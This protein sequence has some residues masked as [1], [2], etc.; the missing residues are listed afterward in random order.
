MCDECSWIWPCELAKGKEMNIDTRDIF[1][2]T[3]LL[4]EIDRLRTELAYVRNQRNMAN[5]EIDRMEAA[6]E[7]EIEE[8]V[9][10]VMEQ[11]RLVEQKRLD[12]VI[13]LANKFTQNNILRETI[14]AILVTHE[15]W[16]RAMQNEVALAAARA[17]LE[18]LERVAHINWHPLYVEAQAERDEARAELA[19]ANRGIKDLWRHSSD[20]QARLDAVIEIV[21]N[22]TGNSVLYRQV[23]SA[24]R[25]ETK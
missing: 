2:K 21:H 11:V 19:E 9:G 22:W 1:T 15:Q 10:R 6:M 17:E 24:A 12:A 3:E 20:Q 5:A 23:R 8:R 25:G 14:P 7:D 4:D 13:A 18:R 16:E